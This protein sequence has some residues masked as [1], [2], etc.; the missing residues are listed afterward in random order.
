MG[1]GSG[2]GREWVGSGSGVGR[3]GHCPDFD[4]MAC[5]DTLRLVEAAVDCLSAIQ[6]HVGLSMQLGVQVSPDPLPTHGAGVSRPT[7]DPLPTHSGLP[8][9]QQASGLPCRYR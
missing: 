7:P 8:E 1:R 3:T 4:C 5:G 9:W 2:V 6:G